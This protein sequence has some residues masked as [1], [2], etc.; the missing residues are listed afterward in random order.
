MRFLHA[1]DIHL[2]SPLRGLSRYEGAPLEA[3]RG[4]TRQALVNLVD[5]A[6]E[7]AVDFLLIAGDLYDGDW[8]DYNT[9]LFFCKQMA[10]LERAEIPVI[11]LCG[12][13]DAESRL[14]R[15]LR[16]PS[17]VRMLSVDRPETVLLEPLRVAIHGQGF[18]QAVVMENLTDNYPRPVPGY[19]NIGLLHTSVEGRPG[20]ARYAPCTVEGLKNLGYDYWAL[21]H[22]HQR[23]VLCRD[24]F[25]V[26]PGN[27]QGRHA[28]ETG[29]K[30]ATLVE[31]VDGTISSVGHVPLD[32]LRWLRLQIDI[33]GTTD[34][35]EFGLL[36][37]NAFEESLSEADGHT[38][39]IRVEIGGESPFHAEL[40][41]RREHWIN[42]IRNLALQASSDAIWIEKVKFLSQAPKSLDELSGGEDAF[43]SILAG[44]D[45]LAQDQER[46][47][48]LGKELFGELEKKLPLEWRQSEEGGMEPSS[49]AM[50]REALADLPHLLAARLARAQ[51][52]NS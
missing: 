48:S 44:L 21:G 14:T 34:S 25:I 9:G 51:E 10:R 22:V 32:V 18:K 15:G 31:L 7:L 40:V 33:T 11:G 45:Q 2:D 3:L 43:A 12:N 6:L 26:F 35:E 16:L 20:H 8:P 13:H 29:E 39:A 38:L 49:L 23:E 52:E 5:Q 27:L 17:N 37:L 24:P 50:L 46:L 1:A 30:G 19:F 42:E 41:G 36:L 4:A 47:Q 28:R